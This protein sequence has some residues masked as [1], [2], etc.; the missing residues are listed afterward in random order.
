M[1]GHL[2]RRLGLWFCRHGWHGRYDVIGWDGCSF[3]AKCRRCGYV[4]LVDS[5]GNLF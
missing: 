3:R 5:Q 1:N 2:L 4:G